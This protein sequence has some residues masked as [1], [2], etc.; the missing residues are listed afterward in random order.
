[1]DLRAALEPQLADVGITRVADLT[2]LDEID[3]P[4]CA[5]V[6]PAAR[7]LAVSQGKGLDAEGAWLGAVLEALEL[8][9]AEHVAPDRH[10]RR[11]AARG[12]PCLLPAGTADTAKADIEA[13]V[14]GRTLPEGAPIWVPHDLVSVDLTRP[15][16]LHGWRRTSSGLGAGATIEA[17][18]RHALLEVVERHAVAVA[19]DVPR[20]ARLLPLP[21]RP[22]GELGEVIARIQAADARPLLWLLPSPPGLFVVKARLPAVAAG[23]P[24]V[25]GAAC[26]VTAVDAALRALLECIQSRATRLAG[27]RDDL[28]HGDYATDEEGALAARLRAALPASTTDW[29]DHAGLP[30]TSEA[31]V[32]S[33]ASSGFTEVVV[34][35]LPT[36][37]AG[38]HVVRV[39]VPGLR[40]SFARFSV[41]RAA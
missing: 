15:S 20:R 23:A 30:A 40:N 3:V 24:P 33:L 21:R 8:H 14:A 4:V 2:G 7:S 11:A 34:V 39:L 28:G 38:I 22:A 13:W 26:D 17:A 36:P 35:V 9:A 41:A 12:A 27:A 10:A 25:I 1:M 5:A 6:R 19:N 32:A 29:P 31:V 37:L 18:T 16:R